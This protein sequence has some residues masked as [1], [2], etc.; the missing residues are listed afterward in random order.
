MLLFHAFSD[1]PSFCSNFGL[2]RRVS[3]KAEDIQESTVRRFSSSSITQQEFKD[4][5]QAAGLQEVHWHG[6]CNPDEVL[7]GRYEVASTAESGTYALVFD[8]TFSKNTAKTVLYSLRIKRLSH[9]PSSSPLVETAAPLLSTSSSSS[10][11]LK[12]SF[13][14]FSYQTKSLAPEHNSQNPSNAPKSGDSQIPM[15]PLLVLDPASNSSH[16]SLS[17]D[18]LAPAP[19]SATFANNRPV[20]M[21]LPAT[22]TAKTAANLELHGE[23]HTTNGS[24]R[25]L[26]TLPQQADTT[27]R[28][29]SVTI[30]TQTIEKKDPNASSCISDGRYLWG[31][32]L[33]KRRKK[34][35]GYA[36]RFF[37]LDYKYGT[38]NYY[39]SDKS[40]VLR[41]SMPIKL[42]AITAI[43]RSREIFV[44]SGMEAWSLKVPAEAD[45]K[46][47][48][49]A[50]DVVRLSSVSA[51]ATTSATK[52]S[53][54]AQPPSGSL[55]KTVL[56][57]ASSPS[58][59]PH[60]EASA[61]SAS[62][63]VPAPN[64]TI[65]DSH[66]SHMS[67]IIESLNSVAA[68]ARDSADQHEKSIPHQS[69][70]AGNAPQRRASFWRRRGS[71]L[72]QDDSQQQS[73]IDGSG[74]L[75]SSNGSN[76]NLEGST[77]SLNGSSSAIPPIPKSPLLED[78][79]LGTAS[80]D[81]LAK[82]D[83]KGTSPSVATS[84]PSSASLVPPTVATA[85]MAS[86]APPIGNNTTINAFR[87]IS[88]SIET[89]IEE[90]KTILSEQ[91][92]LAAA[93][94][95]EK[96]VASTA[97]SGGV[98]AT[99]PSP[100]GTPLPAGAITNDA[101]AAAI[102]ASIPL[103]PGLVRR[104]S[105]GNVSL[106]STDEFFDAQDIG[107]ATDGIV[108]IDKEDSASSEDEQDNLSDDDD[109][110]SDDEGDLS[111]ATHMPAGPN[112][113]A[114]FEDVNGEPHLYPLDEITK[115]PTRRAV[116]P[117]STASPPSLIS[118]VR[119]S[120]GKDL[121][122]IAM[123]VT[124]NE[125]ITIL[126][127]MCE[128]FEYSDL[129]DTAFA[130]PP[131]SPERILTVAAFANSY[132]ASGRAK[133]RSARKPFN[134]LLGETFEMVRP[135][136]GIR[137]ITE[138]VSHR[139]P[140]M[141]IQAESTNWILYYSPNPHQQFWGKSAEI[142]N[143]GVARLTHLPSR[144]VF[145]WEQPTTFLRNIIAGEKYVEP[146][147]SLVVIS[148]TGSKAV[149]EYK[150]G[151]MFSGR[152]ED[153]RAVLHDSKGTIMKGYGLEGKWT[154]SIDLVTPN[155]GRKKVWE[156][157]KLVNNYTKRFG[158]TEF[159]ASLN[160]ITPI[161]K[162]KM[163][164]TDSRLRP[165]QRVYEDGNVDIAEDMKLNLEEMQRQRRKEL[166]DAKKTYTPK[167]FELDTNE[168]VW[169]LKTG[170]Q[171]YWRRR[172][173]GNWGPN[174]LDDLF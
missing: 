56:I 26:A 89:I 91:A 69:T 168:G 35:Q 128:I 105:D 121:S 78:E 87:D 109:S 81:E 39:L 52:P 5:L 44:D 156:T 29:P 37:S 157:G 83:L 60:Y 28:K 84:A 17:L 8:N 161:E 149:I 114:E 166:E 117:L 6:R 14:N 73:L 23:N 93:T 64:F 101:A 170:E 125:P 58:P 148:S 3:K 133:E 70:P 173:A 7:Q 118:L 33:K 54:Y 124:S 131:G 142:N 67:R 111:V 75:V 15:L 34:L 97:S 96:S 132:L 42:C 66:L 140:V 79:H 38:L 13:K 9:N 160:E 71:R 107:Q 115:P 151:S 62:A 162:S 2:Y 134:P 172:R 158:F 159:A 43:P 65:T 61:S 108:Y 102:V 112:E 88:I 92:A 46:T 99:L 72:A 98:T 137:V 19:A 139:P 144:E 100:V 103:R 11:E 76:T 90:F 25:G 18:P 24:S 174:K 68:K 74:S 16:G 1:A 169:K 135:E 164:P 146:V 50:L 95:N 51:S 12:S 86:P 59:S 129:V 143:R 122:T 55:L 10:T 116:I 113:I 4:R 82:L 104:I 85:T 138:K 31:T 63:T 30:V 21:L 119:K 150:S 141:A 94:S 36:R 152:S 49:A 163:A 123:P 147:G 110:S 27:P 171:N 165:D 154:Q 106:Y 126:Q 153:L 136:R 53:S 127:R 77:P 57:T 48:T 167:F 130:H 120:V 155:D 47:W 45:F 32:L 80:L 20:S 40:S 22:S 145:E 41:G